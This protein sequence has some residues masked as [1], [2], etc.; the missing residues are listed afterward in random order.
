MLAFVDI[1]PTQT[2]STACSLF[3]FYAL[4]VL[5]FLYPKITRQ[6]H[7]HTRRTSPKDKFKI[8]YKFFQNPANETS[9][10][11]QSTSMCNEPNQEVTNRKA[12]CVIKKSNLKNTNKTYT[13]PNRRFLENRAKTNVW[14]L[15][16][17]RA[18]C[19]KINNPKNSYRKH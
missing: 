18:R 16:S 6:Q 5:Y 13:Q 15:Y 12:V 17:V 11:D 1:F 3:G 8:C 19:Q 4:F 2:R 7:R 10:I 14:R 9:V